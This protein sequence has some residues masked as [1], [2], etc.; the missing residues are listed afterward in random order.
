MIAPLF[1]S[2]GSPMLYLTDTPA[3]RFLA[4]SGGRWYARHRRRLRHRRAAPW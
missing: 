2:H 1:L 3:H 4:A